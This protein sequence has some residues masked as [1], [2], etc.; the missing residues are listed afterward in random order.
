MR[1]RGELPFRLQIIIIKRERESER[2]TESSLNLKSPIKEGLQNAGWRE[3]CVC[4]HPF[5]SLR[6]ISRTTH[7]HTRRRSYFP[8]LD[9]LWASFYVRNCVRVCLNQHRR[10]HE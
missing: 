1:G 9:K 6:E 10:K 3:R 7:T 4:G 5:Q 2:E 8:T